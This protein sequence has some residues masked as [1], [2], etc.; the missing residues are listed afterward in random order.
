M[1]GEP[2]ERF[3]SI[4]NFSGRQATGN[5]FRTTG[6][7]P[8]FVPIDHMTGCK[9]ARKGNTAGAQCTVTLCFNGVERDATLDHLY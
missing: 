7:V 2:L 8:S 6:T 5:F 1:S 9:E 3:A 4:K